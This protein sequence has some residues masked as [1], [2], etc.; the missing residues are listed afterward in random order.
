MKRVL[1]SCAFLALLV[2]PG[3][4]AYAQFDVFQYVPYEVAL[5]GDVP[6]APTA[7]V[8]PTKTQVYPSPIYQNVIANINSRALVQFTAHLGDIKAGDTLC[9]DDVY[10]NSVLYFN[11][12]R[13][14]LVFMPG[15][16][17]WTDCHR[18]NNGSRN[19]IERLGFLRTTF[20]PTDQSWGQHPLTLTRQ[21]SDAGF[22]LYKENVMWKVGPALFVGLN[23][24]GSNNNRNRTSGLFL[25]GDAE[26]TARNAANLAWVNKAFDRATADATIKAVMF[27]AQANPFERFLEPTAPPAPAS[28]YTVS[29]YADFISTLR[30]RTVAL[31]KPVVYVGGDTHYFRI[32]KPLTDTYPGPG[33]VTPAGNRIMNFTRVEVFGQNDVHWVKA[34]V[35]PYDPNIFSFEPVVVAP[36]AP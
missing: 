14:A 16:N 31:A 2:A 29:G 5:I 34:L 33:L 18:A 17:E 8:A 27:I 22:E 26:Y 25:D 3:N 6:Y 7:G 36:P 11:T 19:P 30:S 13:N 20:Y 12:F 23:L 9:N 21:S 32:D 4:Q 1:A 24:P 15:D 10:T 35:N 28:V